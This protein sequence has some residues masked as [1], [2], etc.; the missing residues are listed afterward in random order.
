MVNKESIPQGHHIVQ[1][2]GHHFT[3]FLHASWICAMQQPI[4]HQNWWWWSVQLK[5]IK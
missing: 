1:I 2:Q 5:W 3:Y 4:A